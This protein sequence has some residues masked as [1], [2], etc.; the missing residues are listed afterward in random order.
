MD[1]TSDFFLGASTPAL[2][3]SSS[4]SSTQVLDDEGKA[5][6]E[7]SK[8]KFEVQSISKT[9]KAVKI[10]PQM[11]S[12]K[13]QKKIL[14]K[15]QA[16]D[17]KVLKSKEGATPSGNSLKDANQANADALTISTMPQ[18]VNLHSKTNEVS[19]NS[20]ICPEASA[21]NLPAAPAIADVERTFGGESSAV[22]V[23]QISKQVEAVER[24][25]DGGKTQKAA[26]V[27]VEE[28]GGA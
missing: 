3:S 11:A 2:P 28:K 13:A 15:A 21:G 6:V 9:P 18:A 20:T 19:E 27:E 23:N 7:A 14:K 10:K 16:A 4:D 5:G 8:K 26:R 22:V 1:C 24:G 17:P 12:P 25:D